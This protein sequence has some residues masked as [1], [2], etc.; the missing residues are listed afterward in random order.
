MAQLLLLLPAL[1]QAQTPADDGQQ[2][3]NNSCRTCHTVKDGDNRLGPS[4][5]GIVGRKAGSL[6]WL[7]FLVVSGAVRHYLG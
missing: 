3:F 2:A 1:G 4:L 5:F 6:R 7:Q